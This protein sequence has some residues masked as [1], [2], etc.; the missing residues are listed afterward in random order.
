MHVIA[1]DIKRGFEDHT[2]DRIKT[3][4]VKT[5]KRAL[6]LPE[7]EDCMQVSRGEKGKTVVMAPTKDIEEEVGKALL[8]EGLKTV[9]AAKDSRVDYALWKG[10]GGKDTQQGRAEKALDRVSRIMRL[11]GNLAMYVARAARIPSVTY[12]ASITRMCDGML[13]PV[14]AMMAKTRG[15]MGGRSTSARI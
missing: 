13:A 11:G 7:D 2:Q 6:Q 3:S 12:G 14:R 4:T 15:K 1:N 10:K 8:E 9:R 5:T